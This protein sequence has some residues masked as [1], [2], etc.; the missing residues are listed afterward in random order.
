MRPQSLVG[1]E[2]LWR[3]CIVPCCQKEAR[4]SNSKVM[5]CLPNQVFQGKSRGRH[6]P[7]HSKSTVDVTTLVDQKLNALWICLICSVEVDCAR[8]IVQEISHRSACAATLAAG[9]RA[10]SSSA[11]K[12]FGKPRVRIESM[13]RSG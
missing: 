2:D 4:R 10:L 1:I 7:E 5:C 9:L 3:R 6:E 12:K 13:T 8:D 11:S